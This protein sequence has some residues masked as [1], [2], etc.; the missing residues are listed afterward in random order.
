MWEADITLQPSEKFKTTYTQTKFLKSTDVVYLDHR[1][2][3]KYQIRSG[4]PN[5][6][7]YLQ[8]RHEK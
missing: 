4:R 1:V 2:F 5:L 3:E 7:Q 6:D 8:R